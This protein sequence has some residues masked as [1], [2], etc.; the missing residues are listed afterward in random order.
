MGV[1][2]PVESKYDNGFSQFKQVHTVMYEV[3]P[4]AYGQV[5]IH[6]PT[7]RIV[8]KSSAKL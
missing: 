6:L 2:D 3:L 7:F 5:L 1:F 8:S 4:S